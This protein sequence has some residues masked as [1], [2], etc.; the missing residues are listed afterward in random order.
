[1]I[2][3]RTTLI[4]GLVIIIV[5][6]V[7]ALAGVAYNRSGEPEAIIELAERE[8]AMPYRYGFSEENSGLALTF[9]WRT[10]S[11]SPYNRYS[12]DGN[13]QSWLNKEK[14]TEIG[15]DTSLPLDGP[16]A[17]RQYGKMLPRKAYLVMEYDGVAHQAAISH[18]QNKLAEAQDLFANN[19]GKSEFER[20][21]ESAQ[22]RLDAEKYKN[23]RLFVIDAGPDKAALQ[24]RYANK[25]NHIIMQGEI[26]LRVSYESN[27]SGSTGD[28]LIG[29]V[30]G[31]NIKRVNIA[32]EYHALFEQVTNDGTNR[33]Q[34][35]EPRYVVKLAIGKRGE[36]W[37]EDV[38][39]SAV[40]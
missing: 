23:S 31:I 39:P 37:V 15:F 35:K 17:R 19:P 11:E 21:L 7:I 13:E 26:G 38:R 18:Q 3:K 32:H 22:E 9:Y 10:D 1:M 33:Y 16:D 30:K 40:P 8:L 4:T 12:Y 36:P 34:S 2:K 25:A 14:L 28:T 24:A 29:Y 27:K 5:T 20:Q 6:N